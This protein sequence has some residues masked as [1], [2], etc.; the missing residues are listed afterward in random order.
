MWNPGFSFLCCLTLAAVSAPLHATV[1][2]EAGKTDVVIRKDAFPV[3]KFAAEEAANFLSRVFGAP[4]PIINEPREGRTALILGVNEWSRAA[5]VDLAG[6]KRDAYAVKTLAD[7]VLVAGVDSERNKPMQSQPMGYERGTLMG[8]YGFLEEYAGCRFYFPGALGEITPPSA[9]VNIPDTDKIVSPDMPIRTWY[10]DGDGDM[11]DD[12]GNSL[13]NRKLL[14]WLRVRAS[15]ATIKCCHG[16]AR[17]G[18]PEKFAKSHPEYFSLNKDG[19]RFLPDPGASRPSSRKG[20]FCYSSGIRDEI[21]EECLRRFAR[22]K[23]YVD[24]MP[25]DAMP[26]CQCDKCQAAYAAAADPKHPARELIWG[27]TKYV[28]DKIA[29]RG[30]KGF[31]TQMVYAQYAGMPPEMDI[32]ANVYVMIACGG[33]RQPPGVWQSEFE[34]YRAWKRKSANPVWVWNYLGKT[35]K[36]FRKRLEGVPNVMP[37][38]TG[39]YYKALAGDI[40]GV[41]AECETDKWIF[42]YL[43][44]YVLSHVMWDTRTDVAA[45][46]GEHHHLMFGAGAAPMAR[47]YDLLEEKWVG[48]GGFGAIKDGPLGPVFQPP[49]E[50]DLWTKVYGTD[51]IAKLDGFLKEASAAVAPGSMEA[52]RIEFFRREYYDP[53]AA[54]SFGM[55]K[56]RA[57]ASA[58]R[59]KSGSETPISLVP[60]G[61]KKGFEPAEY[62]KTD[63]W[64]ERRD[65]NVIDAFPV[66]FVRNRIT[67]SGK[68]HCQ[69]H[70]SSCAANFHDIGYWGVVDFESGCSRD[71]HE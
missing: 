15:S 23:T 17:E 50:I 59:W 11:Y 62:V 45:L 1:T 34:K 25:N 41:F 18:F 29:E 70:W 57:E 31:V 64:A 48:Y 38:A 13:V 10:F 56:K 67:K 69:Y 21:V 5:G 2:L 61:I 22:G 68:G 71:A 28:A 24:I 26:L 30:A 40:L 37:R 20:H 60:F 33:P 6:T 27:Y 49:S 14:N 3:V 44:Y 47:F 46:L 43:N 32:P 63:V 4:V 8:V 52:R 54:S 58:L 36:K 35:S 19:T 16:T 66:E 53:L 39:E 9:K 7:K 42:N 65:G 51:T 12:S 55:A